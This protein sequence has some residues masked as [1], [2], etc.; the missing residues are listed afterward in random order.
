MANALLKTS[1]YIFCDPHMFWG[2]KLQP[3]Q[4]VKHA[5]LV[6]LSLNIVYVSLC[7]M[8]AWVMND[9]WH[10]KWLHGL[11]PWWHIL[12]QMKLFNVSCQ[13]LVKG[14]CCD[15]LKECMAYEKNIEE[16]KNCTNNQLMFVMFTL[17]LSPSPVS[18][19]QFSTPFDFVTL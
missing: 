11:R 15:A 5:Q 2:E 9:T 6:L 1:N 16:K 13:Y 14:L 3:L 10:E 4:L 18:N 12:S 19:I 17:T 8:M 7:Y